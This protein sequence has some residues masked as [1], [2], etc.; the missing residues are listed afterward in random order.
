MDD[1]ERKKLSWFTL[2]VMMLLA[3]FSVTALTASN[4]TESEDPN[5]SGKVVIPPEGG[6][7]GQESESAEVTAAI[8][9]CKDMID[10]GLL[11]SIKR[12]S[13]KAIDQGA[14]YLIYDI[15]TYGGLVISADQISEYLILDAG[16]KAHTVA[17]VT[18]KAVSAGAL[19]S[20]ACK[21]IVMV[22][23]TIIGDCAPVTMGAEMKGPE[24]EKAESFIRAIFS[25]SAKAN[26]YPEA[27]LRS[28]VSQ[29][30]EVF[31][32]RNTETGEYEFFE[33]KNLPTDPNA[34]DLGDTK[35]IVSENEILTLTADK[36][37]EYGIARTI[38][39]DIDGMLDFFEKRDNV[40][41]EG[42]PEVMEMLWSEQMVRWVN[43]PG[44][45]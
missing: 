12:R 23:D 21:D 15:D 1:L 38:V 44:V 29:R 42:K 35:L 14:S 41:F 17:F 27:L 45:M 9:P 36:A 26:G 33:K 24:R 10:D 37:E 13:K 4:D 18:T 43:S 5:I 7:G 34:W 20:V 11:Q 39:D 30:I 31:R 22:E 19:I 16:K 40:V 25:R 6:G 32:V 28:M 8:I 3:V 2:A